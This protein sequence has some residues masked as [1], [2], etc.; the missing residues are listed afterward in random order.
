[1]SGDCIEASA[2]QLSAYELRQLIR[3]NKF[4]NNTSGFAQG[5]VQGNIV[6]LPRR[7]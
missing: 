6:I 2:E 4:T 3:H 7:K 1:M 5:C